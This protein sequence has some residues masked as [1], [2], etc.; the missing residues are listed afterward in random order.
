MQ[1]TLKIRGIPVTVGT[2]EHCLSTLMARWGWVPMRFAG[3]LKIE[4]EAV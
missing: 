3:L 2:Y 4:M 1:L